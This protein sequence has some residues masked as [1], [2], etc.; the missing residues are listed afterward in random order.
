MG[1]SSNV[2]MGG[3]KLLFEL[4]TEVFPVNKSVRL[5]IFFLPTEHSGSPLLCL[6]CLHVGKGP[7]NFSLVIREAVRTQMNV[8]LAGVEEGH[9]VGMISVKFQG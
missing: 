8:G 4:L 2:G 3:A 5:Q 6:S 7:N 1:D 9:S